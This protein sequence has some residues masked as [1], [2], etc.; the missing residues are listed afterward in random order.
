MSEVSQAG[1][2]GGLV[3]WFPLLIGGEK[4]Y[5]S[6]KSLSAAAKTSL[7]KRSRDVVPRADARPNRHDSH[8]SPCPY[9]RLGGLAVVWPHRVRLVAVS[10][11]SITTPSWGGVGSG[12]RVGT[13]RQ[14]WRR[15]KMTASTP[16][17]TMARGRSSATMKLQRAGSSAATAVSTE[18]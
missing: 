9:R 13:G 7:A 4:L 11:H 15:A 2:R 8:A 10:V 1:F 3:W 6:W 16:V 17:P 12:G 5:R 18:T 14:D